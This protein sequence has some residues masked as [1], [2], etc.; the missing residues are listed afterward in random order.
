MAK[1]VVRDFLISDMYCCKCGNRGLSIPR[2]NGRYREAGH[3]K[4]IFCYHCGEEVNHAEIR[5]IGDYN[6][7]DFK[8][9][10]DMGRFVD[11]ERIA[12]KDLENCKE[13]CLYNIEGKCWNANKSFICERR[14]IK[15]KE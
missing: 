12:I 10:F 5:P 6:L 13:N 15:N 7:A 1:R 9:E 4:K 3:L 8:L 14:A 11:G 2:K